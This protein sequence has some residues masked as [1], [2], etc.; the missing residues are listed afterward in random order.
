MI[1][2]SFLATIVVGVIVAGLIFG[3][4]W[5]LIDFCKLPEP[6]ARI[7]KV[8]LAIAAVLLL[9]GLLISLATGQ[10]LFKP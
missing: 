10:A 1:S 5:W 2:L 9:I 6:F 3:L 4:L 8:I 7:A